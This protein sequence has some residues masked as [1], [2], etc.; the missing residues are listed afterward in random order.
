M[1]DEC[2]VYYN[3]KF[4][5][6][7]LTRFDDV[8]RATTDTE[9]FS[10]SHTTTLEM[11]SP[12][13]VDELVNRAFT[14]RAIARL[15]ARVHRICARLL[16]PFVGTGGFDYVDEF[17]ALLPP[18]VILE[19]L[20]FP[21]GR[22]Q[23]W[24]RA[25]D[26]MFHEMGAMGG[27][28]ATGEGELPS[29]VM[30][31]VDDTETL[32][33]QSDLASTVFGMLP[34]LIEQRRRQPTDDI[35]STLVHAEIEENGERRSI[36]TAELYAFIQLLAIAGTE[37]VARLLSWM[38]VILA[39]FPE[40]R[41]VVVD[42]PALI[43]NAVEELLRYEAPSPVNGRWVTRDVEFHGVTIPA[44]SKLIMLN[45]AANRDERAFE[46]PNR[47]DVRRKFTKHLSLGYG[48]HYCV[49]AALARL[50][51]RIALEETLKRWPAWDVDESKIEW[52]HTST[53]RGYARV[54]I[55]FP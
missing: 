26:Q 36:T 43:P 31:S 49:G 53:V 21:E 45:G 50:E 16:D 35:L 5:F 15:E 38:A 34:E 37:T 42:N 17:G 46:D 48:A 22:E 25:I 23:E 54:P 52:A 44:G 33:S 30:R 18:T 27:A 19:M 4:D 7:A 24:R 20:G 11:M 28:A 1:R 32:V 8:L 29:S 41:A 2:P 10:S 6:Y 14:P 9:V 39:R 13:P 40:Q 12:D 51:G 47:F 3:D 55:T